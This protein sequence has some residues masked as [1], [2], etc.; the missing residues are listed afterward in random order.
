MDATATGTRAF[1]TVHLR[2]GG[3]SVVLALLAGQGSVPAILH[4]GPDL[5]DAAAEH[6]PMLARAQ[7]AQPVSGGLDGPVLRSV[8]PLESEGWLGTPGLAG[9]RAGRD[10][11]PAFA[12]VDLES[13]DASCLVRLA[14]PLTA[15]EAEW[16]IAVDP[17]GLVRLSASLTNVGTEAYDLDGLTLSLPVPPT[18]AEVL[19]TT[20]R[21]LRER[22]PQRHAIT[23]GR[24]VR[25]SRRGRPGAD[26]TL[27]LAAGERAFGFER[28][29]V[30]ALH[31]AW[32]GDHRLAVERTPGGDTVLQAEELLRSG[33]VR[34]APGESYRTPEALGSWGEGLNDLSARF[35]R[36][37]RARPQHPQRP[38][39]VTLNT[40]EAVYFDLD[41]ERLVELARAGARVGAER[42]VLDDGWFR[43]RRDDSAGLGDWYVD[44]T[45]FPD[46]LGP[47]IDAVTGLGLEFGLWV[48]PEMVNPDS[49]L[50]RAH[51]EWLLQ[52]SG[53]LPLA[54]RRQQVL[55][56]SRPGAYDYVLERIDALL[57]TY[58][59]AYLKW[60][61]NRDLLEAGSTATGTSAVH[62]H[63]LALYRLLDE[64]RRRHPRVEIESCASGGAR[65][66]L[67]ILDRTDRVWT[68]DC[69][70]PIERL[71]IQRYTGLLLPPELMGMHISGPVSHSTWRTSRLS[72]RAGV[73][74]F[75]HLGIEWDVTGLSADE[76]TELA[77]YVDLHRR[78]RPWMH[79]GVTVHADLADPAADLRGVV[80]EDG[81]HAIFAYT[82][83]GSS[84]AYP[85]AVIRFP[86]LDPE[87][88]YE[89]RLL[90][91][92]DEDRASW[93]LPDWAR[94]PI[95]LT[96][97]MLGEVGL[98]PLVLPPEY[99]VLIEMEAV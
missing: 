91:A 21:H 94:E 51:P 96:G 67:G 71:T 32:S 37:L 83:V 40:W 66:D 2:G 68:S 12:V 1:D 55:D 11:S 19:D 29:R 54:S 39:P 43:G 79:R 95:R 62:A 41:Q 3:T 84:N 72:L 26:A 85:P 92:S 23:V 78:L 73:A 30:H 25:E 98:R 27:L 10:F 22:H 14:D 45:V 70:D 42:F 97:R 58:D 86:G 89:V 18:A 81:S 74:L 87:R 24:Y 7:L 76:E 33:A 56:L 49:D 75:G 28:G 69:I 93:R 47:L 38:R 48:E 20:G 82:Q 90:G 8:L 63:T 80:S 31:L 15:L 59:I 36:M 9:G 99:L 60:D 44:E 77:G 64:L 46:G 34:L 50:A 17:A 6:L 5:G 4:W 65:I 52:P 57:A 13:D 53:R 16:R 88:T 35:H 61:H